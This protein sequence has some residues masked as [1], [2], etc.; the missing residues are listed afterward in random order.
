MSTFETHESNVRGYVRSFPAIFT[1]A[2]NAHLYDEKGKRYIDFLA[3]AGALNYGHNNAHLKQAVM[4]YMDG[5]G[6]LHSLDMGT[7]TKAAFLET[8]HE[9]ILKPRGMDYKVQFPGPTGTNAVES[10]LKLA[11]KVTGRHNVVSFT[12][13]FHGMT[14]GSL[15]LTGNMG[16]RAGAGMPLHGATTM[17]FDGYLGKDVNT[18]DY[19]E[20]T[21][22]DA[23]SGLDKPAAVIVETVQGE[24]GVN[25]GGWQWLRRL[26]DIC[27]KHDIL[28]IVDDIQMGCGRTG[29]FFSVEPAA[30]KPDMICLSKAI[31][32]LGL[33][34]A[35]VLIRPE[36]D[37]WEPGEHN[38]TF[39]GNNLAFVTAT[40]ALDYWRDGDLEESVMVKGRRIRERL[41]EIADSQ[42]QT[43][44]RVRGRGM[45]QGLAC[46]EEGL[47][48]NICAA[49]FERG[50]VME[51]SGADDQVVKVMPPLTIE[52]EVLENG[53]DILEDAVASVTAGLS[54][55]DDSKIA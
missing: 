11:R 37:I 6:I 35:L 55:G 29:P 39:R 52:A 4:A 8:F 31:G 16:K 46:D 33:P 32:G 15:A 34:M 41:C 36:L 5:D 19:F 43:D 2:K 53:L 22:I 14:L 24:G 18:L 51:T 9:V 40:E 44:W 38:G 3:G 25:V 1:K 50:L 30:I 17:P 49:A 12:N 28:T 54:P 47:A 7:Q 26:H 48:G 21:L 45:I 10:A 27:T 42:P 13:A 23:G 20:K